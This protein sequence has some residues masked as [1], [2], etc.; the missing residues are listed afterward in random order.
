MG[1]KDL[2]AASVKRIKGGM[3]AYAELQ[4]LRDGDRS[5]AT[6]QAFDTHKDDLGYGLLL[7]KYTANV[8]DADAAMIEKAAND[9]IPR[10]APLFWTFRVM[11]ASGFTMLFIF[12]MAFYYCATRVADQKRWLMRMAVWGIPL[13]W[14]AAETGWFVAEF[15]RQPWTIS[16]I[17]PTHLSV[18]SVSSEQLWISIGGFAL[19]YTVLLIIEMYLMLKYVR[20]GPSSLHTGRYCLEQSAH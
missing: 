1:L 18:S 10:V 2:H 14:I 9:T 13:P 7:K 11:V 3:L 6:K 16:G 15:G 4:K 20:L 17:L 12:A 8:V 19:F 5:E